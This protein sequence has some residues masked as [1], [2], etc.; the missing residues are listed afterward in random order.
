MPVLLVILTRTMN[1]GHRIIALN[2]P[3]IA[4]CYMYDPNVDFAHRCT[5]ACY[6]FYCVNWD[7]GLKFGAVPVSSEPFVPQ[8]QGIETVAKSHKNNCRLAF[9]AYPNFDSRLMAVAT[10]VI[11]P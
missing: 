7:G 1:K 2:L 11:Q 5:D 6:A 10:A 8:T 3:N 9:I 4:I